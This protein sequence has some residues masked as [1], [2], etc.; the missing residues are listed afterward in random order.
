MRH[1]HIEAA[2]GKGIDIFDDVFP[3]S[4][5]TYAYEF[6]FKSR[7]VIGW[8][9]ALGT[10]K[11]DRDYHLHSAFS[12]NDLDRL[13][14][15]SQ[16]EKCP[17]LSRLMEGFDI[18]RAI[19]NLSTPSSIYQIHTHPEKKVVLYYPNLSWQ[20]KWYGETLFYSEDLSE[21]QFA[22]PYVPGRVAVF[23]GAIPH[24]LR[25]QSSMATAFRFTFAL[26]LN[27][28]DR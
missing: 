13:G 8:G 2:N 14:I 11:D 6:F 16:I 3:L 5:R 7:F 18:C 25:P 28:S 26:V 1:R 23:D 19:V 15:L 17:E 10:E 24:T 9:D 27:R 22:N 21:I 4:F 12:D 20:A